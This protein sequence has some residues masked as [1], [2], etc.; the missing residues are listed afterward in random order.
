MTEPVELVDRYIA[1]W[2]ETD[3]AQR[4]ALIARTWRED[5][6]YVDPVM[7]GDGV[8]GIDAMIA[9][10]QG[11]F[12]G[13]VMRRVGEVDAHNDRVRFNWAL[14]PDGGEPVVGG[15]DFGVTAED[16]LAAITGFIDFAPA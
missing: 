2:N 9:G 3:A 16:R 1:T 12:P 8:T 5:G 7:S 13:F 11:R 6:R 14:G 10:V 4:R 15:V